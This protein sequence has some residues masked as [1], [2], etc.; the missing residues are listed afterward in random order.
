MRVEALAPVLLLLACGCREAPAAGPPASAAEE[1]CLVPCRD[2]RFGDRVADQVPPL[3]EPAVVHATAAEDLRDDDPVVGVVVGT[4]SRAYPLHILALHQ[5]VND[6]LG[7][8]RIAVLFSPLSGAAVAIDLQ[9]SGLASGFGNSGGVYEGDDVVYDR[10][11][12]SLFS[13]MLLRAIRGPRL[14]DALRPL[15]LSRL[16]WAAWRALEP[17]TTVLSVRTGHPEL[18]YSAYAYDWYEADDRRMLE[19]VRRVDLRLPYKERVAGVVRDGTARAYPVSRLPRRGT[20]ADKVGDLPVLIVHDAG[21]GL[22]AA[23]ARTAGDLVLEFAPAPDGPG[24]ALRLRDAQ[25]GSVWDTLGRAIAGPLAGSALAPVAPYGCYWFA[26][27][28]FHPA[29]TLWSA[30]DGGDA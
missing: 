5:V 28:A 6:T 13:P 3:D 16:T 30:G 19:P 23:Y 10:A 2:I 25:T 1:R 22:L 26:W 27:A 20:V 24:G 21:A 14:G 8:R 4:E 18:D 7:G 11:T 12:G 17:G 29:T 9:E 15:P